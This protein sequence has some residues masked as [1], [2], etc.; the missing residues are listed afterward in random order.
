MS[1]L[2]IEK[3]SK[4]FGGLAAVKELDLVV[5]EGEILGM[6]GPN[7]AGKT[8]AFN[9]ISGFYKPDSGRVIFADEDITG[10]R[11]D[12]I[13]K[14]GI[15]RTFQVVKPFAQLRVLDN[16][17]VGALSRTSN[18]SRARSKAQDV[19]AFLQ[20]SALEDQLAGS[21]PIASRKR[22]GVA[23]ALAT[24]PKVILLDEA[25]SGLRPTESQEMIELV[26]RIRER[27]ITVLLVEHVMKVIMSLAD[28]IIV[29]HHGEKIAEGQPQNIVQ[30][31]AVIDAYL[32]EVKTDA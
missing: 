29:L 24:E 7:G 11:P 14:K 8:T 31:K 12:Q 18:V 19:L 27:G 4:Y 5:D 16:V 23:K 10:L 3:I 13:C 20:M 2:K 30:D 17:I 25:M 21:L 9:V 1:L 22:L 32:G 15:A 28:R 6:I 26:R